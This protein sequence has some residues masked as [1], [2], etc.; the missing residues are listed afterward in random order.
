MSKKEKARNF[1]KKSRALKAWESFYS[2][3]DIRI[4]IDKYIL[5]HPSS[6]DI[7][8]TIISI[9]PEN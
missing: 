3:F 1:K 7:K 6:K 2:N 4:E 9:I 5:Q 8:A